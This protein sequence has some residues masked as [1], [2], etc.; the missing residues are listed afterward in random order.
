MKKILS[1]LLAL[2]MLLSLVACGND[3]DSKDDGDKKDNGSI[4][5]GNDNDKDEGN[6]DDEKKPVVNEDGSLNLDE[7]LVL[8]KSSVNDNVYSKFIYDENGKITNELTFHRGEQSND[9]V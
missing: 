1:I 2:A 4:F 5:G 8:V 6:K 7:P 3:G 9:Y